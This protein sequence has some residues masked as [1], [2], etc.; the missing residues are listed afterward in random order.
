MNIA[1]L[2]VQLFHN[3]VVFGWPFLL[4]HLLVLGLSIYTW[5]GLRRE[6]D[7]L[8]GWA[9][10][11]KHADGSQATP[12]LDQ[13]I[14]ES[15]QLGAQ[16]FF[17]PMTDFS[18]RLDSIV[19]GK[20]TE[21]Y[22]RINLFLIVGI[23][24]TLFG[25][26]EFAF[27]SASVLRNVSIPSGERVVELGTILSESLAKA[28]PVGFVG[29]GLMFLGQI[30]ASFWENRLK[31]GVADAT[32]KALQQRL[33]V[34]RTQAQVVFDAATR[35]E[36]ALAPI[37]NLQAMMVDTLGPV[38]TE[39]GQR[40]D[41][42]LELVKSQFG[43]LER[44][45]AGF[46]AA[47]S[48]LRSG[49]GTLQSNTEHLGGL[50]QRAP[51]VLEHLAELQRGQ[52]GA[53]KEFEAH[54]RT[55]LAASAQTLTVLEVAT[56]ASQDLP[57][58]I[59]EAT[60]EALGR[61]SQDASGASS[62]MA[63][64]LRQQLIGVSSDLSKHLFTSSEALFGTMRDQAEA[65]QG[66]IVTTNGQLVQIGTAAHDAV[67]G[68]Q[69]LRSDALARL[70]AS[71]AEVGQESSHR[72]GRMADEFGRQAQHQ[73]FQFVEGIQESARVIRNSLDAAARSWGDLATN[74]E[75]VIQG[76]LIRVL[77]Q[78]SGELRHAV[79]DLDSLIA[80]RYPEAVRDVN[81]LTTGLQSLV[82]EVQRVQNSLDH[83][84][85]S[86]DQGR[87][88]MEEAYK[89]IQW[90]AAQPIRQAE[91]PTDLTPILTE[92]RRLD[93]K[94]DSVLEPRGFFGLFGRNRR[95]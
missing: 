14:K 15:E 73:F 24:G 89:S 91:R 49:V 48:D 90:Q 40:L 81:A 75:V 46:S 58:L 66:L 13:F 65:L 9:P 11:K 10:G 44:T 41:Q 32:S 25:V 43:E 45:T 59:L 39:L 80:Q 88:L 6:I 64:E 68:M 74:A 93:H 78:V 53:I 63:D 92:M 57:H 85:Q 7:H 60:Q 36:T 67:A 35:I 70:E 30:F 47:V 21:L 37:Q 1:S 51:E 38:V 55:S 2:A 87:I 20:T 69:T 33:I 17:V 3:Y 54:L 28:F 22:E 61:I 42:S 86:L 26:F 12:I 34:S 62:R 72:W 94:L 76:P 8:T 50:L 82:S 84:L 29:L 23:A 77:D 83:W 19:S 71:F 52:E 4:L 31:Q 27:R 5:F 16:G 18:D 95:G 79:R 56:R